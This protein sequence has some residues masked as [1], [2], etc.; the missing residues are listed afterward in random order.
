MDTVLVIV[1][2]CMTILAAVFYNFYIHKGEIKPNLS[3][4]L[5]W[6]FLQLL[7]STTFFS[8]SSDWLKTTNAIVNG[9]ANI[10]ILSY[11]LSKGQFKKL[12]GWDLSVLVLGLC[13]G[14]MWLFTK[15]AAKAN[16]MLQS[17][18]IIG[19]IPT[20]SGLIRNPNFEH[21]TPWLFFSLG[22]MISVLVILARWNGRYEEIAYSLSSSFLNLV[23][24]ALTF[25]KKKNS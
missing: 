16:T 17:A 20:I 21:K 8:M 11:S 24:L 22:H 19:F 15:D 7:N 3:S 18:F 5:I 4:W 25:R 12:S 14:A 23:V 6:V 10:S 2:T 9:L 13:I 1:A